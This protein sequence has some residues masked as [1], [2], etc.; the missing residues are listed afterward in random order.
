MLRIALC[1]LSVMLLVGFVAVSD[2]QAQSS[3]V[4]FAGYLG[5]TSFSDFD[6]EE[7]TTPASGTISVN[8][9]PSFAGA[10]GLRLNRQFRIEGEVSYKKGTLDNISLATGGQ[11]DLGGELSTWGTMLNVY[12][13]FDVPWRIQPYVGAGVGFAWHNAQI[14]DVA[15]FTVNEEESDTGLLWQLGGGLKYRVNPDLAFTGSYRY[16]G[17]SDLG[18]GAF[19]IDYGGGHELRVGLEYDLPIATAY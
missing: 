8:N 6:F 9:A 14:N 15:G 5:T 19:D 10:L 1:A 12:Y 17:A 3:R 18:F 11:A 2:A 13:D 4:Y 7:R 16:I